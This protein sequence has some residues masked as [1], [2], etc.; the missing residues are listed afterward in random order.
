MAITSGLFMSVNG[1][2]KYKADFFASYFASFI[3]NGVFPNPSTGLQVIANGD[4]TVSVRTGKAWIKGYYMANDSDYNLQLDVADGVLKRIDRI[5]LRLDFLDRQI[6]PLVKKGAFATV[7]VAP[8]LKRDADAYELAIADVLINNGAISVSQANITDLRLNKSLCGIVHGTVDQ[9]D[10]TGLF[11]QYDDAFRTWFESI[12]DILDGDVAANL[13]SRISTVEEEVNNNTTAIQTV[14]QALSVHQADYQQ[15]LGTANLLTTDKTLK[16]ALNELF[17]NVSSGKTQIATAITDKGVTA[18]GG[19]TFSQLASK[20]G[21]IAT[22]KKWATGSTSN[23]SGNTFTIN[24]ISFRPTIVILF[25]NQWQASGSTVLGTGIFTQSPILKNFY[26]RINFSL[27]SST[28][29]VV[30]DNGFTFTDTF[31][32]NG[33]NFTWVAFE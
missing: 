5:V 14:G 31:D 32:V 7:P 29:F 25:N 33:N 10:T 1:D 18:S 20:I 17:T 8:A 4:M 2:R 26:Y 22:G 24:N 23:I 15:Q 11:A 21:Q 3:A 28:P 27:N 13:A 12:Q 9:I 6:V 19:D 16:G 30:S